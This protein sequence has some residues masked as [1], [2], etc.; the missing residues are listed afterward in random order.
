MS[1]KPATA[2]D[3][4][5]IALFVVIMISMYLLPL[6]GPWV[7]LYFPAL[8]LA[9]GGR[10]SRKPRVSLVRS[11]P[12]PRAVSEPIRM[13]N[14][15][16]KCGHTMATPVMEDNPAVL[17]P[18]LT[19]VAWYCPD[20]TA[21]LPADFK[22]APPP[23]VHD[24]TSDHV[25]HA[26]EIQQKMK[27]DIAA[28]MR[29]MEQ[30][31]AIAQ[32]MIDLANMIPP[33]QFQTPPPGAFPSPPPGRPV[34]GPPGRG[35][36]Q[37]AQGRWWHELHGWWWPLPMSAVPGGTVVHYHSGSSSSFNAGGSGGSGGSNTVSHVTSCLICGGTVGFRPDGSLYAH[38]PPGGGAWCPGGRYS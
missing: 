5:R 21:Q 9:L 1:R 25:S 19:L 15:E 13:V 31:L 8:F 16:P 24:I 18:E 27:A 36:V 23:E 26:D 11:S 3:A 12:R 10:V 32:K 14:R 28:S 4:T 33:Q 2:L 7:L 30:R 35:R 17:S 34:E 37:D 20:C 29:G 38:Q 22:P 6:P